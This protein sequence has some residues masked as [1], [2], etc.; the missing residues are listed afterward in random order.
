[1]KQATLEFKEVARDR[2]SFEES[3]DNLRSLIHG[4]NKQTF[5]YGRRGTSVIHFADAVLRKFREKRLK[6]VCGTNTYSKAMP[7]LLEP[8][9]LQLRDTQSAVDEAISNHT[10]QCQ[11]CHNSLDILKTI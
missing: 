5:P 11:N 6:C 2:R 1:M 8:V 7:L 3:Q 4:T 10:V 9:N